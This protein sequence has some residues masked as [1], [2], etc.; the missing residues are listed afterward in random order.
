MDFTTFTMRA[1]R[2]SNVAFLD[3]STVFL[4]VMKFEQQR[5]EKGYSGVLFEIYMYARNNLK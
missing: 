5:K 2:D 4:A 3:F 1:T